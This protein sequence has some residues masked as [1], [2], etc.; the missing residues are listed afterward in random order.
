MVLNGILM[1]TIGISVMVSIGLLKKLQLFLES[2]WD[3]IL[4][5][6]S[7]HSNLWPNL[8]NKSR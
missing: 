2:V 1:E 3:T 6:T 5:H 8:W 7:C 4:G